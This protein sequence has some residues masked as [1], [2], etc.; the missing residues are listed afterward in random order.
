MRERRYRHFHGFLVSAIETPDGG[1]KSG[2]EIK[3]KISISHPNG[4][5]EE[6][7]GYK[8]W[9]GTFGGC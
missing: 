1:E 9:V 4:A 8:S 5:V 3:L 2:V 6:T 7:A